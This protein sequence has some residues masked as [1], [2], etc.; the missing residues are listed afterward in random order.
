MHKRHVENVVL[1]DVPERVQPVGVVKVGV[2]AEHLLH[3]TL[4]VFVKC[5]GE[6]TGFANPLFSG[7]IH[8]RVRWCSAHGLVDRKGVWCVGHFV[9]GEHDRIM[10]L[11]DDPFFNT[12]DELGG[13][14]L[15]ST[16]IHEPGIGKARERKPISPRHESATTCDLSC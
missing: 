1:V 16:P 14:D 15:R 4:A 5:W 7:R 9:G 12:V 6:A 8:C 10:N 13:R 11:A 2:T 3:D